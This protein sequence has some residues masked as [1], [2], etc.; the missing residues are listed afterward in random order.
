VG[1]KLLQAVAQ[2]H[3]VG[4]RDASVTGSLGISLYPDHGQDPDTLIAIADAAMYDAKRA[5]PGNFR[6][7]TGR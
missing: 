7:A 5:G 6:L 2:P 3:R 1:Q 4:T